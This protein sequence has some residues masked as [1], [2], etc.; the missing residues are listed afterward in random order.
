L[1]CIEDDITFDAVGRHNNKLSV[2]INNH[3]KELNSMDRFDPTIRLILVVFVALVFAGWTAAAVCEQWST[4]NSAL[5]L[6]DAAPATLFGLVM[7]H[8]FSKKRDKKDEDDKM[9]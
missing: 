1:N 9:N 4:G 8:Y 3:A 6:S 2:G 5:L 7:H